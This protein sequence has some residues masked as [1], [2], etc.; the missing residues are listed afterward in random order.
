MRSPPPDDNPC[1]PRH[2]KPAQCSPAP[3]DGPG[4]E[5]LETSHTRIIIAGAILSLAF[6]VVGL[7]LVE[8]AGLKHVDTK[9]TRAQLSTDPAPGRADIIDRNGVLLATTLET[10]SLYA[11]PTVFADTKLHLDA[12]DAA[13]KLAGVLTDLDENTI[14]A[15]LTAEKKKSVWLKHQLTP[16]EEADIN[17]LGIPGIEFKDVAKRIYP[18]G[19]LLAHVVGYSGLD[20]KGQAGIERGLEVELNGNRQPVQLS[21]DTRLQYILHDEIAHQIEA[22]KAN[23]GMGLVMD[24]RSGEVLAMVSLPDFDPASPGNPSAAEMNQATLGVFEMGSVFKI[25]TAAMA[26]ETHAVTMSSG[27]DATYPIKIGRF[28]I[29][30]DHAQHRWLTVPEIFKYSSNIGSAK[31]ALAV[32][33]DRQREFLGRLGLLSTPRFEVPE[34]GSPL[35]PT[36]WREVNTMTIGFGHGI[37]VSPLQVA[38]AVSAVVNGGI[39]H[40]ATLLKLADDAPPEGQRVLSLET[41]LN[42][43]KLLRLVVEDGT[44]KFAEAPGYV[45]G[46]KTGTA[47]KVSAHH[48]ARSSLLSS[49]VG[50]F[51]INDP[52]Y[53]VMVSIDEPHGNASSHGYATGGWVSAPA[54]SHTIE[55]MASLVGI[56]PVDE[57]SPEIRRSLMVESSSSQG[58]KIAAN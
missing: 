13:R 16:R 4:K 50:V 5:A 39:L 22:F 51:P 29:H 36:N 6:L 57:D 8:V 3:L 28:T 33:G 25:F 42:M 23:G 48:Y 41:S 34:I 37:S 26:L 14:Y 17:R 38:T 24:V 30:D 40:K 58:R 10:P 56:Q 49:F 9:V 20:N 31:E 12:H 15:K 53:L 43:R 11:D 47:E 52:R 19:S 32:G 7:R 54:V 35:Y 44:G 45:V 21:I 2:F 55:R 27:F 46:G 1:R 18:K